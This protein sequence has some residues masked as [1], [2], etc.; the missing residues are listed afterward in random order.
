MY[1]GIDEDLARNYDPKKVAEKSRNPK[2]PLTEVSYTALLKRV[3]KE[4]SPKIGTLYEFKFQVMDSNSEL[5]VKGANY[6]LAFFPG[7]SDMSNAMFWEN[8]SPILMAIKGETALTTFNA[9]EALGELLSICKQDDSI[10][11]DLPFRGQRTPEPARINKETGKYKPNHL[12]A[13]GVTPKK[14]ARDQF[15]PY[16]AT[17][18]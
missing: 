11:L 15:F 6:T 12:E 10:E 2:F 5:V 13:D 16:V 8:I 3:K 14:F 18:N 9:A 1:E 4:R 7:A 17:G